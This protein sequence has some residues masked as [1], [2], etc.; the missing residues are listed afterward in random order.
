MSS[1]RGLFEQALLAR[2]TGCYESPGGEVWVQRSDALEAVTMV[3][4]M[5]LRLVGLE[6]YIVSAP[7]VF[8]A[9]SR[10]ADFSAGSPE[11][12]VVTARALL[13]GEWMQRP[14]DV[15]PDAVG[16]YMIDLVVTE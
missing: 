15:H 6:G 8:P 10:I 4:Q 9:L 3:E 5:G 11:A 2:F 12:A 14:T 1:Q 7:Q 16:D 13:A